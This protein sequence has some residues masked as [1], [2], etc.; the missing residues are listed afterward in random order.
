MSRSGRLAGERNA[1]AATA[2]STVTRLRAI[3]IGLTCLLIAVVSAWLLTAQ[4]SFGRLLASVVLTAPLWLPLRGLVHGSRRTCAA[5]TLC[6]IPYFVLGI[7]E[8]VA[9]PQARM[10]AAMCLGTALAL[11]VVLVGR[12]RVMG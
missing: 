8:A 5:M 12:L 2:D 4:F 11:F 6:V 7:T 1:V 3:S 10:W 9:N